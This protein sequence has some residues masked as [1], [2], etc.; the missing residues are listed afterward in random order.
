MARLFIPNFFEYIFDFLERRGRKFLFDRLNREDYRKVRDA[1]RIRRF[2]EKSSIDEKIELLG[3]IGMN[4][5]MLFWDKDNMKNKNVQNTLLAYGQLP[6]DML[7][8]ILAKDKV[9]ALLDIDVIRSLQTVGRAS[10]S[11]TWS[12]NR[13]YLAVRHS[14]I[15]CRTLEM[16]LEAD[17]NLLWYSQTIQAV[18]NVETTLDV[19]NINLLQFRILLFLHTNP[20]GATRRAVYRQIG[21]PGLNRLIDEMYEMNMVTYI[22]DTGVSTSKEDRVIGID[23]YGIIILQQIFERFP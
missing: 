12:V 21:K 10:N 20:N 13:R 9:F 6:K 22:I 2:A 17:R 14:N 23:T 7:P 8:K 16:K 11:N 3:K 5:C 1:V 15:S 18:F 4:Y 19:F